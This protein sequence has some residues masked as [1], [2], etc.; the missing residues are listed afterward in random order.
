MRGAV[1]LTC[2]ALLAPGGVLRPEAARP[3]AGGLRLEV[4]YSRAG[5]P[6]RASADVSSHVLAGLTLDAPFA[7]GGFLFG[8]LYGAL[9]S[10]PRSEDWASTT[11]GGGFLRPVSGSLSLGI[12]AAGEAF[13]VGDPSPYQAAV[14][15]VEPEARLTFPA[16]TLRAYGTGA[17]GRSRVRLIDSFVRD[18]RFGP[19]TI[20]IGT[21]MDTNLWAVGGGLTATFSAGGATPRLGLELVSASAGPFRS[22]FAG[23]DLAMPGGGTLLFEIRAWDTPTG[24]ETEAVGGVRVPIGGGMRAEVTGGRYGP[25]PL[26]DSPVGS[27][28]AAL[29]GWTVAD[30]GGA[31]RMLYTIQAGD[32]PVVRFSLPDPGAEAV[33]VAGEFNDWAALP[34]RRE[35]GTWVGELSIQPGVYRFGFTVDGEWSVPGDAPGVTD[36]E[37][38]RPTATLL[39]PRT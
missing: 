7:G 33:S 17:V 9:G 5:P 4:G 34:L 3:Q 24:W 8:S 28:V 1:A 6:A 11:L 2:L 30:I 20:D 10:G 37:W 39:I 18:T 32:R 19:V 15:R 13:T 14:L 31:T 16:V 12:A 25:N 22:G 27:G 21:R 35:G 23:L 26:L 29:V 38:G 36:D